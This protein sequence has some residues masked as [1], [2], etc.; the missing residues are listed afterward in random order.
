[1]IILVMGV[2]GSGKTTIGQ[3]LAESL[4]WDFRDADDFH[5]QENI[6]KMRDGI[7]LTDTDRI[8]WLLAMQAAIQDWLQ[9]NQNVV[10]ACSALKKDYRQFLLFDEEHIKLVYLKG[11]LQTIQKRL[12]A[13]QNHF[14]GEKLLQSQFNTLEEPENAIIVDVSQPPEA[15]MQLVIK[16]L[17]IFPHL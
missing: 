17:D 2:A 11:S 4:H 12:K 16:S 7:P 5:S 9:N 14:M 15:I 3:L 13:R 6:A 1:M 8:P 10:L